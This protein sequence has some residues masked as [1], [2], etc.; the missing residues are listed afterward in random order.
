MPKFSIIIPV[1]N[2]QNLTDKC[3][4]TIEANTTDYELI[5]ID[6]GSAPAYQG[7]GFIIRN[8]K[9]EG[10]PVAVNQG[11]R[12]AK[13]EI[14]VILN[15]DTLVSPGWLD[16]LAEHLKTFD[17]IG[18]VTN[19]ISG[20]QEV[21]SNGYATNR[22]FFDF[23]NEQREK[24]LGKVLSWYRL[25]FFCVAFKREV[26][27]KVGFLDERFS[28]GNFEDDD[29]CLR[30]I[31]AGF[32]L[33]VAFDVFIHHTG[34]ATHKI[35]NLDCKKLLETNLIKFRAK[36]SDLKYREL[37]QKAQADSPQNLL[38]PESPLSLVMI[39]KNEAKG[40][41]RAI[42]S[43]RGL[44]SHIVVA[45]DNKTTDATEVIARR[46]AAEIKHFDF[47]DDFSAARNFAQEGVST[48]WILFLDGHEYIKQSPNLF[49]KL[50]QDCDGLLCTVEME[51][52]AQFRNP[53]IFKSSVKF[54]GA[55]HE[56]QQCKKVLPYFDFIV[57]HHRIG[58]QDQAAAEEREAQRNIHLPEIMGERL[59][60]NPKDTR[61]SFHLALYYAGRF[62]FKEAKKYQKLFLKYSKDFQDRWFV[63]FNQALGYLTQKKYFR[64]YL[65]ACAADREIPG[66]WEVEKLNG[67]IFFN[68]GNY[69]KALDFLVSSF[70]ENPGYCSFKPWVRDSAGTWS[71]IGESFFHLSRFYQAGEAFNRASQ[72]AEN[73]NF[74][75]FLIRRSD[76]MFAIAR[77]PK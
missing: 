44:V 3:L 65:S 72:H 26:L 21:P 55:I 60:A 9:N 48:P 53:R 37:A 23:A 8:E 15:N 7:P 46:Y 6:N 30:A 56:Q 73:K 59:K 4:K 12:Q 74:R 11:L 22:E 16:N 66:R 39:V 34:L 75:D 69:V 24:N 31:E 45:I 57:K 49:D 43:C 36:W 51:T 32:K 20:I 28:P 10:F 13:G 77:Q 68:Q 61:A 41:E 62:K 67:I 47:K 29:Y 42:L 58:G 2:K 38:N 14:L 70:H 18:P 33:G 63:L 19:N 64:A 35:L 27:E 76:L 52:G 5:I 71:L 50:K 40:I 54:A 1:F 17:L 25:V